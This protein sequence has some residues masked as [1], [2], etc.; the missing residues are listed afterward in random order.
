MHLAYLHSQPPSPCSPCLDMAHELGEGLKSAAH[1]LTYLKAI[2]V[3][4][5]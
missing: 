5:S 1:K 3:S 4:N 2:Y